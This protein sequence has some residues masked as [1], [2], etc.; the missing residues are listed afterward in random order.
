[1]VSGGLRVDGTLGNIQLTSGTLFGAG[2]VGALSATAPNNGAISPG[3]GGGSG[4][5]ILTATGFVNL[6]SSS[7]FEVNINGTT[8][9]TQ[10]DRLNVTSGSSIQL[11]GANLNVSL[12]FTPSVGQQFTIMQIVGAGSRIGQF[13]QG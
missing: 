1:L 4:A 8:V 7:T 12:G 6:A 11:N 5:G 2:T 13:A 9:G 10:Y 3:F